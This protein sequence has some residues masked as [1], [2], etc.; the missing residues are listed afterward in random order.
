MAVTTPRRISA[1]MAPARSLRLR[2][3][4]GGSRAL[5]RLLLRLRLLGILFRQWFDNAGIGKEAVNALARHRPFGNPGLR[6]LEIEFQPVGVVLRQN[7]IVVADLL[8]EAAVARRMGIRNDN[9]VVRALL[10]A[11]A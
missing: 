5:L 2:R 9:G 8:D 3:G 7:G 11:T 4:R 6:L 10:R 1:G